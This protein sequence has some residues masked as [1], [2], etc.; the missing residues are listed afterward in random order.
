MDHPDKPGGDGVEG[1]GQT[2][3]TAAGRRMDSR[4]RGND[5]GGIMARR[6]GS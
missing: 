2:G 4:L 3:G 5:P 6:V 1:C